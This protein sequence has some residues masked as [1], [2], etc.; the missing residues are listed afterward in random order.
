MAGKPGVD[1]VAEFTARLPI[2]VIA[3]LLGLPR[4]RWDWLRA[5]SAEIGGLLEAFTAF[6]PASMNQR[7]ADLHDYFS[8]LIA[9]RRASPA[10]DLI[11]ALAATDDGT[12]L[13]DEE[14]IAMIGLLM[15][16][17]HET[18]TGLLGNSIV[19]LAQHP[20][21]RALLRGR[22]ELIDNAVEE[23]L[24]F[25]PPAQTSGRVTTAPLVVGGITIPKGAT[26]AL[27][28]GA[29]NRDV[30]RWP[31]ANE[32]RLDRTDPKPISFGHGIHH[33]LGASLARLETKVALPA[34]LDAFG[35]YTIDTD[36]AT[37]K[38]SHTLRGPLSLTVRRPT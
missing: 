27:M 12:A 11:S 13:D 15:F 23:L 33:C 26:V 24:R 3:D 28:I 14:V 10:D 9:I 2:Y 36:N 38:R 8:E 31:D 25:D 32:L 7:F 6:D 29:A 35:D 1:I 30:R 4:D 19:A 37:W 34:F 16:A 20:T 18:T 21:Q 5:A 22:P 17:G